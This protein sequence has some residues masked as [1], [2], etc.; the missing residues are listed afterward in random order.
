MPEQTGTAGGAGRA[1][2]VDTGEK[3]PARAGF[4]LSAASGG[5]S[6]DDRAPH[7]LLMYWN[8]DMF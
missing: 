4:V 3:K 2:R 6:G 8:N 1:G 5:I 7:Q